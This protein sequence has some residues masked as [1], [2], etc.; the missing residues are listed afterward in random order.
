MDVAVGRIIHGLEDGNVIVVEHGEDVSKLPK[1]VIESLKEAGSIIPEPKAA[2]EVM[3]ELE[4]LKKQLAEAQAELEA[5]K[6]A[7]P[8]TK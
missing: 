6:A 1:D 7:K 5:A 4:E 2:S 3:D 8:A